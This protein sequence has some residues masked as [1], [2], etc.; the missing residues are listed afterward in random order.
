VTLLTSLCQRLGLW[1]LERFL[2]V[3]EA[4]GCADEIDRS[5]ENF[6]AWLRTGVSIEIAVATHN[7]SLDCTC[8][9]AA[10]K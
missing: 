4:P 9:S 7:T 10:E 1:P 8:P 3:N 2:A 6:R 5:P